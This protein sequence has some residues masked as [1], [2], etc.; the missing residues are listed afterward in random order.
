MK[1]TEAMLYDFII[2]NN[3]ATEEET[4]LVT[5]IN[6]FNEEALNDIIFCRTEYHDVPQLYACEP[7]HYYFSDELLDRYGLLEEEEEEEEE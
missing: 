2:D 4:D 7:E 5:N 3:I 6:G 1:T